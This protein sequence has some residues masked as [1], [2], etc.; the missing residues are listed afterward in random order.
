VEKSSDK[1]VLEAELGALKALD[2]DRIGALALKSKLEKDKVLSR[3]PSIQAAIT[4]TFTCDVTRASEGMAAKVESRLLS[5]KSLSKE[6]NMVVSS[7]HSALNPSG[8]EGGGGGDDTSSS[9]HEP[10]IVGPGVPEAT[11]DVSNDSEDD[12]SGGSDSAGRGDPFQPRTSTLHKKSHSAL[13]RASHSSLRPDSASKTLGTESVFLP[14]LS[15]GFIPGGSN[16][17]WSDGEARAA[18][19]VRKNR[20]GQRARRAIWEK[21]YGKAAKHL[22]KWEESGATND[23]R[24]LKKP[25]ERGQAIPHRR[26]PD[27]SKPS[28]RSRKADNVSTRHTSHLRQSGGVDDRPLHPSWIAKMRMKE[29]S[30][31]AIVPSQAKRIKFDD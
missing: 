30:D 18:D 5:S 11:G 24:T 29:K 10:R 6:V 14:T 9:A 31:A 17:D 16:T 4:K 27:S 2:H 19:F 3:N 28:S 7:L 15:N 13:D 8:D 12:T 20:R 26:L 23:V 22:H 1:S 25:F 21:K